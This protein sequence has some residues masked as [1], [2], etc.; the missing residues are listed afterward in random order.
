MAQITAEEARQ[1]LA[2]D[3]NINAQRRL[4]PTLARVQRLQ[5]EEAVLVCNVGPWPHR[6]ERPSI[7]IFVPAYEA[8][9]DTRKLGYI[10]SDP[11]PGIHRFAKIMDEQEMT[12]CEDDGR[13]VLRDV[14]GMGPGL[15]MRQSLV[16]E[17]VF[18]PE[19]KLPTPAEV[20]I[21]NNRLSDYLDFLIGEAR[22]ADEKGADE[23]KATIG[24]RHY[25][26]ARIKGI[27]E[28]WV[29][30]SAVEQSVRCE[31]CGKRNP[32]GVAKCQCGHILDID[33]YKRLMAK[34][35]EMLEELNRPGPVK[36]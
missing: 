16:H 27:D 31:M 28:K 12:W 7:S 32:A 18:I 21:A 13:T 24:P 33:L 5:I 36:K 11:F 19:D 22:D 34:Q 1:I 6:L 25:Q 2:S 8:I 26:A 9:K 4:P 30:H 23:R 14:I 35:T 17:G 3:P 20:Q 15:P 29:T 10:A